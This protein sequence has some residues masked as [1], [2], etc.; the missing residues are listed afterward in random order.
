V[1]QIILLVEPENVVELNRRSTV[2]EECF[3]PSRFSLKGAQCLLLLF[4]ERPVP[5]TMRS[6]RG[7]ERA[8]EEALYHVFKADLIFRNRQP[9]MRASQGDTTKRFWNPTHKSRQAVCLVGDVPSEKLVRS[10]TRKGH[11]HVLATE[12][13]EIPN[14]Q[15]RGVTTGFVC[16]LGKLADRCL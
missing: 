14:R 8:F 15:R 7:Q 9:G 5:V 10:F 13:R 6:I 1:G 4:G 3:W 12:F 11:G 2:A 16:V